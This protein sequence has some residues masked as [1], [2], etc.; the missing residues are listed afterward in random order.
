MLD[1]YPHWNAGLES[2]NNKSDADDFGFVEALINEIS[3]NYKIDSER[4]YTTGYSN[5]A[6]MAY[7]LACFLSDKIAAIGSVAGTMMEE[8]YSYCNPSHPKAVINLHGTSDNIVPY[9][10]GEG[11]KSIDE[12]L[13]YW[14]GVNNTITIPITNSTYDNGTTID[15]FAYPNGDNEVAV[16]HYRIIGG[17]HVWF[18]I[19]SEGS[20]TSRLIW[21]FVSRYD[22]YGLR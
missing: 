14:M 19:T 13:A 12:V 18:D 17:G 3:S 6:F 8:T 11:L 1:G 2:E 20:N 9:G 15:H 16:E 5:G 22:I 4:I 10:G 21:D 7:S